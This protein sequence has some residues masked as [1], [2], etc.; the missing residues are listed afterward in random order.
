M[1]VQSEDQLVAERMLVLLP[2]GFLVERLWL[3]SVE[4][5]VTFGE[6][7]TGSVCEETEQG[8]G[9]LHCGE[10]RTP[11]GG[12]SMAV[13]LETVLVEDLAVGTEQISVTSPCVVMRQDAVLQGE[14][15]PQDVALQ[16][17]ALQGGVMP[18]Y[19]ALQGEKAPQD[20]APLE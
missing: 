5:G 19:V 10:G 1:V 2:V 18:Q 4:L 17:A 6:C 15:M 7:H 9:T 14:V 8:V 16:A 20:A 11:G 12:T 3:V 13:G